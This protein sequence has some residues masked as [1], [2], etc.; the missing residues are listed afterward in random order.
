MKKAVWGIIVTTSF[1]L[2]AQEITPPENGSAAEESA[3]EK[4]ELQ[5][6]AVMPAETVPD[7]V[8][9]ILI[10]PASDTPGASDLLSP[11]TTLLPDVGLLP[12]P[13]GDAGGLLGGIIPNASLPDYVTMHSGPNGRIDLDWGVGK[14]G[15]HITGEVEVR[16]DNGLEIYAD[17][18]IWEEKEKT[19]TLLGNVTVYQSGVIQ[20]GDRAVY[21]YDE[22]RI[23]SSGL[24]A[25]LDP[26]LLE[27][28]R[29]RSETYQGKQI[30][31]GENAGVTTHDV[32]NPNY[33]IRAAKTTVIPN[34]R[35][36][37]KDL[38]FYAG[39]IPILWLPYLSQPLNADLGWQIIPGARSNLGFFI[40]TRYGIMLGGETDPMTGEKEEAWLLSQWRTD[41]YSKRGLGVGLDLYDTR[42][43][44]YP[45]LG[46][47][48]MYYLNDRDPSY[49]RTGQPRGFVNED[50][51]RIDLENRF[52][53]W[54]T[55]SA[56]YT[57]EAN[58]TLLSDNF[59]LEDFDPRT[60]RN[61]P[62]PDNIF[63][64]SRRSANSL[65]TLLAR[66][67]VNDFYQTD[68]RLPELTFD[69]IK[70]PVADTPFIYESTTSLGFLK[71]NLSVQNENRLREMAAF[72]P[73]DDPR[74]AEIAS[75][76]DDRGYARFNTYHEASLP[77]KFN[78]LSLVPKL[79]FGYSNYSAVEGNDT[80]TSRSLYFA[81]IDSSFKLTKAYPNWIDE[82]WGLNGALHVI[83]PYT[84][85]S[86]VSTNELDASF[87]RI[88]TLTPTTRPRSLSV[89]R[90][91]AIDDLQ[92]WAIV[93]MG[94]RNRL[95]TKRNSATHDWLTVDTYIDGF[96]QDSEFDRDFS[97]LYNSIHWAPLPWVELDLETQTPLFIG[98]SGFTEVVAGARFMPNE[99]LEIALHYRLL[100]NHPILEN[101]S[102]LELQTYY[103]LNERWGL[104]TSHLVELENGMLELQSY[105]VHYNTGSWVTSLGLYQR[106]YGG[107]DEYGVQ[108]GFALQDFPSSTIPLKLDAQ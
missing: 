74:Q 14:R 17:E 61:D 3:G 16:G 4:T 67:R 58:V 56:D 77:L 36:I 84:T 31:I 30:Y 10:P 45:D 24:R 78:W 73:A 53:L 108:V 39:G 106:E 38:K 8:P 34:E 6:P 71:E 42:N 57:L 25:S 64:I 65:T 76:L 69:W 15:L 99:D 12:E 60:F 29:F 33:W 40:N 89:G 49:R 52:K 79:G 13:M 7:L 28:G 63:S 93:R 47:L 9:P 32:E 75:L 22:H 83:Q 72:L 62:E 94:V 50:R 88:D 20:R 48:K 2:A 100:E 35:V 1:Y 82:K 18:G 95:L 92:D 86:V 105:D 54:K 107:R 44:D 98:N 27:A 21:Y 87:T 101:S 70:Q 85:F 11:P 46:W 68:S 26:L 97:N 19:I 41:L 37:F 103:R 102:R 90:F 5:A 104:G 23:D 81:G 80:G 55:P 91:T 96:L 59:F 51:Y 66:G 43:P